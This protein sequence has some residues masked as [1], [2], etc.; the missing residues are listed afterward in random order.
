M[1]I[2]DP[3]F[4]KGSKVTCSEAMESMVSMWPKDIDPMVYYWLICSMK[5][6]WRWPNK[7]GTEDLRKAVTCINYAIGEIEDD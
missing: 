7:N 5:Y 2:V 4:Y 1:N 3:D 6:I